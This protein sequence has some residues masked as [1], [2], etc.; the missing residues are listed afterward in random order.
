MNF[1]LRVLAGVDLDSLS[2]KKKKE[3]RGKR[4][5]ATIGIYKGK[6]S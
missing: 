4:Q 3:A 2:D 5:E 6:A 1:K